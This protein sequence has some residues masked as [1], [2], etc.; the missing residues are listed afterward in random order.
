M[1]TFIAK[2]AAASALAAAVLTPSAAH[3]CACGCG[4][5]DVGTSSMLPEGPGG[6]AYIEYDYQNQYINWSGNSRAPAANNDDKRIVTDF[7]TAGVQYFYNRSWGIQV[8][9]PYDYRTFK[10]ASADP[11]APPGAVSTLSWGEMGDIRVRGIYTGFSE[12]M[13]TGIT[14]GLKLPTGNFT[15]NDA[16]DEIDRDTELGTGSTD[17]LLG[18]FHQQKFTRNSPFTWF[19]QVQLDLPMLIQDDYRPGWEVDAAAGIY[20]KGWSIGKLKITPVAQ[21]LGSL[22][23]HDSGEFA[24]GGSQDDPA[25]GVAS[26]YQRLLLSPGIE[27]HFHPISVYADVEFPVFQHETGNQLTAPALFKVL[28]TYHF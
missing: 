28:M 1:K 18:G 14:F 24:S 16:F 2:S 5:F 25:D 11:A 9:V 23:G 15:H 21:V 3:A 10:T 6:M 13:S 22:R 4:I 12:D 20:Y 19:A 27:F 7:I 26:G 17:L 8:D